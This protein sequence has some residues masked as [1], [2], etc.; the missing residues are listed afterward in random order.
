MQ[1]ARTQYDLN[2]CAYEGTKHADDEINHIYAKVIAKFASDPD[3]VAKIR[4]MERA[5]IIYRD[6]YI[7]ATYPARNKQSAY[8]TRFPMEVAE[9]RAD[10]TRKQIDALKRLLQTDDQGSK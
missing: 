1:T 5:W 3:A 2:V 6:A 7:E 9:L 4:A 8:G 10:L